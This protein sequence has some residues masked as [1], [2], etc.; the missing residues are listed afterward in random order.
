MADGNC[1]QV[2]GVAEAARARGRAA[3]LCHHALG[4]AGDTAAAPARCVT[5]VLSSADDTLRQGC[6]CGENEDHDLL[7]RY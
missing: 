4:Q 2:C 6:S 1:T 3:M 7:C 5:R